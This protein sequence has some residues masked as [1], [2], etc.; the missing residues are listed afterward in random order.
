MWL[1]TSPF[2]FGYDSTGMTWSDLLSGLLLILFGMLSL[3]PRW[4]F[5]GRWGA[6]FVGAWLNFAPLLFWARNPAAYVTD[7]L[8]GCAVIALTILVPMMPG[9]AHHVEMRKR[10]P[11]VPPGWSYNPSSWPQR[12]PLIA[13]GFLGWFIS[14]YLAA[15]Q[16]GYISE[17]WEPFFG[18]GTQRVLTSEVS[19]S[20]PISDAGLGAFAYTLEALMGWMGATNRWRTMPWMVSFFG[21]L[22]IPLG[23]VHV[24]LVI[25]QPVVVGF[26]CTLCLAAAV[27]MLFMIPLTVDEVVAMVQFL[28]KSVRR[29]NPFWRT[30]WV[31]GTLEGEENEDA[32]TPKYGSSPQRFAPAMVWGVTLPWNLLLCMALGVWLMFAPA[33]LGSEA[34]AADNSPLV[35]ALVVT[36]TA[37]VTAEVIRAGRY[38]NVLLGAWIVAAP[39]LLSGASDLARWNNLIVGAALILLSLPRGSINERYDGWDRYIR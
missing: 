29:G 7:S 34:A 6:A 10:G 17:G 36:V 15:V 12:A 21:I 11:E 1:I 8:I 16:L 4:D 3:W 20:M 14:R 22:V 9:M 2:T 27:V 31:G 32:R 35:G 28:Q 5:I 38:L 25:L 19:H 24:I 18:Q 13:L 23:L 26:W 30:F 37:C 39:W 33:L